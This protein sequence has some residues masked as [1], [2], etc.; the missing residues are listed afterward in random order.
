M[1][2]SE[3]IDN[4]KCKDTE[5]NYKVYKQLESLYMDNDTIT[6]DAVY[7]AGK[8]LVDNSETETEK[9]LR[10]EI[11]SNITLYKGY[12]KDDSET[13]ERLKALIE[14]DTEYINAGIGD[15]TEKNN[16]IWWKKEIKKYNHNIKLWKNQIK[17]L[18]TMI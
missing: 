1:L 5:Y 2:Y 16:I 6:K 10:K 18:K 8:L 11:E 7:N 14:R 17:L 15:E 4:V 3:F 9:K 13:I 12:I